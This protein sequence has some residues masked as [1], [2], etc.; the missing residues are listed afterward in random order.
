MRLAYFT[1]QAF[2][3][4]GIHDSGCTL[5]VFRKETLEGLDLV[6]G[7]HRFIPAIM[8]DRGFKVGEVVVSHKPRKSGSSKY[9]SFDR[10]YHGMLDLY[11]I[12]RGHANEHPS[13]YVVKEVV[14]F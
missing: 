1:R 5:K 13:S 8:R 3:H 2:L 7:Q 9:G 12:K 4:D 10:V 6:S 11:D 14:D